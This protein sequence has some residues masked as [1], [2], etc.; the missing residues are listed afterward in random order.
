MAILDEALAGMQGSEI[1][2]DVVFRLYDTYGFP[3]DL[4]ND[5]ARERGLTLDLAGYEA[6]MEAQRA[7]SKEGGH[8]NVDYNATLR[9]EGETAFTGYERYRRARARSS[10]CCAMASRCAAGGRQRGRGGAR[11]HAVLRRVRRPGG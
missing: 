5:I 3:V 11:S 1:P 10:R 7:R 4:T 6:A 8:F 9:L 2:G